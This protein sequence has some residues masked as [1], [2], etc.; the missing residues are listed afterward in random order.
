[1]TTQKAFPAV[2]DPVLSIVCTVTPVLKAHGRGWRIQMASSVTEPLDPYQTR[3]REVYTHYQGPMLYFIDYWGP[4][5]DGEH[6][7]ELL[8]RHEVADCIFSNPPPTSIDGVSDVFRVV[9]RWMWE[10]PGRTKPWDPSR[11]GTAASVPSGAAVP[12]T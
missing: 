12:W 4:V 1:M 3:V 11:F 10:P 7:L 2:V 9:A 6:T 8:V 5:T